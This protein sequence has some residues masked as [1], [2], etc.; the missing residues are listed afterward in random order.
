MS[1]LTNNKMI[2][3]FMG[4]ELLPA[5]ENGW[6]GES[7]Y[8]RNHFPFVYVRDDNNNW[9]TTYVRADILIPRQLAYHKDFNWIMPVVRRIVEICCNEDDEAFE[10]EE[11]TSILDTAS[12]GIVE[13][14]YKVV[15]EF[16]NY[17]NLK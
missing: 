6:V 10:S 4:H 12:L 3:A 8:K 5:K 13:E 16:I 14:T 1:N 2:A 7:H 11:Y 9:Q 17:Y 15:V